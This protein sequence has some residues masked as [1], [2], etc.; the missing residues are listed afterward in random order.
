MDL[1]DLVRASGEAPG[2]LLTLLL[3]LEVAGFV[4]RD[5]GI[6]YRLA[7]DAFSSREEER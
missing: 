3:G 6:A 4:T 2:R 1:D 7:R 5:D